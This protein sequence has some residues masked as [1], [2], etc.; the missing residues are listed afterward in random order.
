MGHYRDS[1]ESIESIGLVCAGSAGPVS[2]DVECVTKMGML[3]R[4]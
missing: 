3:D 2:C 4:Q 1:N